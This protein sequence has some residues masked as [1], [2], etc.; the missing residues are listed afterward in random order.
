MSDLNSLI[1]G[2]FAQLVRAAGGTEASGACLGVSHQRVSQMQSKNCPDLPR[3]EQIHELEMFVGQSVVFGALA[4]MA[5]AEGAATKDALEEAC[6]VTEAAAELLRL[7]R[8]GAPT[9]EIEAAALA[10]QRE[11]MDVP[12]AKL[13]SV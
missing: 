11:A 1:K 4:R 6:D 8:N 9:K 5:E 3:L 12:R 7:A 13:R 2:H 10:V